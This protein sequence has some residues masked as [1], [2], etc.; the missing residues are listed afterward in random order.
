MPDPLERLRVFTIRLHEW[1]DPSEKPSKRSAHNRRPIMEFSTQLA[2]NYSDRVR[3]SLAPLSRLLL[4]LFEAASKAG[5][6]H[7]EDTR[8][9]AA[10]VQ[11]TV[12]CSWMRSRS[13]R[14]LR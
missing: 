5:A 4:E 13:R 1:C 8:R 7:V 9:S 11:Q 14:L 10:L 12:M 2:V 3:A 6:I